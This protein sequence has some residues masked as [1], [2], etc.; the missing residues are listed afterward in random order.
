MKKLIDKLY[1]NKNLKAD[2]LKYLIENINET[3]LEYLHSL[4]REVALKSYGKKIF[5]RGL[6][7]FTNYC[8]NNCYYCGIRSSNN[9]ASRYRLS[10]DEILECCEEGYNLGFRTFV[11]QGGEDLYF[12]DE[13]MVDII[14]TIREKYPD[15][16][17]TLSVGEKPYDTYKK[18]F[19]AGA[20]RFLLRHETADS[21]HYSKLHP[22][23]LTLEN[24]FECLKNLK[25]IG[26]QTG[27]GFMVGSPYQSV[28]T[29][30]KD[31]MFIKE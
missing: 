30:I 18:Y 23:N 13:I 12:T 9:C 22:E 24:R 20:N 15:C 2:E 26:F 21:M 4:A 31:L 3:E 14:S 25:E 16:A 29:I 19:E 6:I 27:C 5:I 17:I 28:D 11:L 10:K 1:K 7:E 8:K